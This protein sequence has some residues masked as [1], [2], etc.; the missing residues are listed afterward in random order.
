MEEVIGGQS[1]KDFPSKMGIAY[2]G[3]RET[4]YWHQ[5]VRDSNILS[6]SNQF[7]IFYSSRLCDL[8]ALCE[9]QF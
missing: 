9:S 4:H 3:V 1:K 7:P 6:E 2:K 8:P 5:L